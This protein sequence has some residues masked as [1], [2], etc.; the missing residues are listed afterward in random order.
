MGFQQ[1]AEIP[2]KLLLRRTA[3]V[4]RSGGGWGL[5]MPLKETDMVRW[6]TEIK[7]RPSATRRSHLR[8]KDE[9]AG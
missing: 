7:V 8:S 6:G 9:W 4:T 1:S 3:A 5:R 2:A